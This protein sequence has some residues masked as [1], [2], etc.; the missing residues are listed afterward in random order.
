[1]LE[2]LRIN[3]PKDFKEW[4]EQRMQKNSLDEII[5]NIYLYKWLYN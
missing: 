3:Y 5:E 4:L 1:L 2:P